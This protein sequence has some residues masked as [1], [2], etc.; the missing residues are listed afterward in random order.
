[1]LNNIDPLLNGD[2]LKVLR[3]MGHGDELVI[4]DANF[5]AMSLG[6]PVIRYDGVGTESLLRAIM[7]YLPLDPYAD[8][9]AFRMAVVEDASKLPA[10]CQSYSDILVE[11]GQQVEIQPVERFAFYERARNAY[12]IIAS[13]ERKPYANLILKKGVI[14]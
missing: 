1:M 11:S 5:P 14:I 12:V 13:G 7:K 6:V 10:I 8:H 9:C 4:A 2:L 3:D